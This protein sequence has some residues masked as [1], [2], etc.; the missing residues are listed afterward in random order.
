MT[1]RPPAR[2]P[3]APHRMRRNDGEWSPAAVLTFA[4]ATR[5]T[6]EQSGTRHALRGWAARLDVRETYCGRRAGTVYRAG[7]TA[8]QF[9]TA[10]SELSHGLKTMWCLAHNLGAALTL[11]QIPVLFPAAGW[12][13][14][15]KS[16]VTD[17]P[18]LRM[19]RGRDR[20][21]FA[22]AA[23]W[24][25]KPVADIA[26]AY[27]VRR[28]AAPGPDAAEAEWLAA[29][30]A[31]ADAVAVAMLSL[32]QWWD[33]A[34]AG[35]WA[36]TG[37]AGAW[38]NM[39]HTTP[40]DLPYIIHDDGAADHDRTAVYGGM[41]GVTRLGN[42]PGERFTEMDFSRAYTVTP[43]YLP[44]PWGRTGTFQRIDPGHQAVTGTGIGCIAQVLIA[45]DGYRYP[46][47]ENGSVFYPSGRYVTSLA[48]PEI[49]E[50]AA[51][52]ELEA[53]GPGRF[54]Q[55][56]DWLRH[57]STACLDLSRGR[58]GTVPPAVQWWAKHAGRAVPGKFAMRGWATI[59]AGETTEQG[60]SIQPWRD[61][62]TGQEGTETTIAGKWEIVTEDGNGDNA[63]PAVLAFIESY[64]RVRL[65]RVLDDIGRENVTA[66]D[67]DG[68]VVPRRHARRYSRQDRV[69]RPLEMR[70]K[71]TIEG[72]RI[73]GPQAMWGPQYRKISGI[74]RTAE[75]GE[76]GK[77]HG[78]VMPRPGSAGAD[79]R[80]GEYVMAN[81]TYQL[82]RAAVAAWVLDTGET[83]PLQLYV[84]S[85]GRNHA[86]RPPGPGLSQQGRRLAGHQGA[87]FTEVAESLYPAHP[88]CGRELPAGV[89]P[90]EVPGPCPTRAAA[91]RGRPAAAVTPAAGRPAAQLAAPDAIPPAF[92]RSSAAEK[93]GRRTQARRQGR[94]R[95]A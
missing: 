58:H 13:V 38:N 81:V 83:E 3:V 30:Q 59:A 93:I 10:V 48:S 68:M 41:R 62:A 31:D 92:R 70:Q 78:Q 15:G 35:N 28:P 52:G 42:F 19:T 39:R 71:G 25:R 91:A 53:I 6:R 60:F 2:G 34:K 18:W 80:K 85:C 65:N 74:S 24:L 44:V 51:R 21:T 16:V 67:T 27:R 36:L 57:W 66:W 47:R 87:E 95:R 9:T 33:T 90:W 54:H 82:P 79:A 46:C 17:S 73:A 72:M 69:T 45:A 22:D 77:L 88:A 64:V 23:G 50:S 76:D 1:P 7:V 29:V 40:G 4:A 49:A 43:A 5:A 61:I 86:R 14:T 56:D 26:A 32:M 75:L 8:E 94:P 20:V 37:S 63:Y 89:L 55:L 84:G 11:L 12:E